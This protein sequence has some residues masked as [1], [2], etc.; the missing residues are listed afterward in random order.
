MKLSFHNHA[1]SA[2]HK[3]FKGSKALRDH[4]ESAVLRVLR[5]SKDRKAIKDS[6][7]H[8]EMLGLPD[9]PEP[10]APLVPKVQEALLVQMASLLPYMAVTIPFLIYSKI[11]QLGKTA[12]P[13]Q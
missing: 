8:R 10:K 3:V 4:R 6:L 1:A 7:G 2:A 9:L 12:M 11:I 5:E 13:G